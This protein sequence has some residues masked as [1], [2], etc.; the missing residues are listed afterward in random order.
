MTIPAVGGTDETKPAGSRKI[1]LGDND[2]REH[3]T[4][5]RQI[6]E[7]DHEYPSSGQSVTAGQH[8]QVTLQEQADLGTG[9]VDATILGSQTVSGVGELVYTT[10]ADAD[11]QI[12][13]VA[14][15]NA[16]AMTGV[17]AAANV[18]SLATM[19][20]LI[21]PVGSQYV[22]YTVATNPGTLLGVGTWVA[23][24][25]K[26]NSRYRWRWYILYTNNWWSK[27]YRYR[28]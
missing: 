17:Y 27:N 23:V 8:K 19:M 4:Q 13:S 20:N 2:I 7:I 9:A 25:E 22:N 1:N 21:Y 15:I 26:S 18:A 16:A 12:T 11:I 14:G 6:M 10:E 24:T 28:T 3:K 5:V